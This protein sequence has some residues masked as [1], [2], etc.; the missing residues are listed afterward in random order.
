MVDTTSPRGSTERLS[1]QGEAG[2]PEIVV[3]DRMMLAGSIAF[4]ESDSR[5]EDQR[6]I[7]G[8]VFKAMA[9][10]S[11]RQTIGFSKSERDA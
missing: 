2:A 7:V 5:V 1:P 9:A 11:P 10:L 4:S 8:R 6:E 3:T